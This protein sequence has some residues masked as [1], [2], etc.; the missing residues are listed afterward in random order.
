MRNFGKH[1]ST[2][3]RF[4]GNGLRF[5]ASGRRV[6]PSERFSM[7]NYD[8]KTTM[9]TAN[10]DTAQ[11]AATPSAPVSVDSDMPANIEGYDG[12]KR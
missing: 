7:I 3:T 5:G 6:I 2:P 4:P 9:Q 10:I 1:Q 11:P 12:R 8:T